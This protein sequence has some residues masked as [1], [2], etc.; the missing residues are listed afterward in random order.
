MTLCYLGLGSNL[1][2]PVRQLKLAI[3]A[4]RTIP[5]SSI[6]L[7]SNLYK[8]HPMGVRAQ[9]NYY[10]MVIALKTSLPPHRL[11]R[12]CQSIE[13]KQH[14]IRRARWGAR[15][16]DIDILLYGK[17]C[18]VTRDLQIPHPHMQ[19]RD[20]VLI[21]LL[22]IQKDIRFPNGELLSDYLT[23]CCRFTV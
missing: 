13:K 1:N 14:R 16:I 2:S 15:T 22:E 4:L 19:K 6:A 7:Q 8:S 11:L 10:N 9:P 21:P 3:A 12:Y 5:R 18:I 20:F 17:K 23:S